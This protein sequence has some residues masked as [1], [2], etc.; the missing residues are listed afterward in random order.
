MSYRFMRMI[1]FFDLPTVTDKERREYRRFRKLLIR[2][3]F[4]MMQES[5]YSRLVLNASVQKT[6]T[7]LI[8]KEKPAKGLIQCLV[9]TEKQF[10]GIMS[11]SGECKSDV[12]STDERLIVL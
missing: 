12:I 7:D 2:N 6:V 9:V 10:T 8:V 5:I 4:V 11:I 3:G 1:V